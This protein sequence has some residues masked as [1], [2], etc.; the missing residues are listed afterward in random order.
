MSDDDWIKKVLDIWETMEV[1]VDDNQ[2][3][4]LGRFRIMGVREG[5]RVIKDVSGV[6]D[7]DVERLKLL[8]E[9]AA[10][11]PPTIDHYSIDGCCAVSLL[12]L[13]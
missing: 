9:K 4:T 11:Y 3:L 10:K 12:C 6:A 5:E 1:M 13:Y 8:T 2:V 7:V